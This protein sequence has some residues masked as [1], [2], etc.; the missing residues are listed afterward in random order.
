MAAPV[1]VKLT[2]PCCSVVF[3]TRSMGA[4][5][6]ISGVETDLRETGS[7]EEVRRYAVAS[8][9]QC[10][11]SDYTHSFPDGEGQSPEGEA[12]TEEERGALREALGEYAGA[13][14]LDLDRFRL[15]AMCFQVRGLDFASRAELALL[16]YY[17]ARDLGRRD[18]EP[19]LREEAVSLLEET[20]EEEEL[21][22]PLV[23]RYAYL[24][25][26]LNRRAGQ[27]EAAVRAFGRAVSAGRAEAEVEES[28]GLRSG[29]DLGRL[30]ER[31]LLRVQEAEAPADQLRALTQG[32]D[33]LAASEAR[34]V[35]AGRRDRASV[36]AAIAAYGEASPGERTAML[37]ELRPDP[38]KACAGVFME[39]LGSASPEDCGWRPGAGTVNDRTRTCSHGP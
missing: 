39:A 34:R 29:I 3:Q 22:G 38:P 18:V 9:P 13:V 12:L 32:S 16:G 2:C 8:C 4:T 19:Q 11:Y 20:L 6:H 24:L 37:R 7:I 35:L 15:A 33:P 5:Y 10:A 28:P 21:P 14:A 27:R 1:A 23:L 26:E 30:A 31:M 17:V 25:G 36:E